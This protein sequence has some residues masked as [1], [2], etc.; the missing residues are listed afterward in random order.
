MSEIPEKIK[1]ALS[2]VK[3]PHTDD[4]I[5]EMGMLKNIKVEDKKVSM[6]LV[7]PGIGCAFCGMVSQMVEDVKKELKE[8]GYE[9]EVKIGFPNEDS[10]NV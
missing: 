5:Y 3:D 10:D 1:E 4:S 8:I 9:A 2:K 7:P 6:T